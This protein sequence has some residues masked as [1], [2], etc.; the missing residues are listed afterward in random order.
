M[1]YDVGEDPP[2]ISTE[3]LSR[4]AECETATFGHIHFWGFCDYR[5]KAFKPSVRVAGRAITLAIPGFCSTLLHYALDRIKPGDI[6]LV[7]RL[8]DDRYACWGGGLTI[9]MKAAGGVA[10]VVDGPCTDAEELRASDFPIWCR[11]LSSITTRQSGSG[12]RLNRPVSIGGA[13]VMPGDLVLADESGVFVLNR[14]GV[15]AKI[16]Q[17][18]DFQAVAQPIEEQLRL[19]ASLPGLSG[20]RDRVEAALRT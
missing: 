19:G 13:V 7:D 12:G 16:Q 14:D 15:E 9:G 6:L 8:G 4:L 1:L 11:G 10:A 5:I 18:L 20:A 2:P 17:A 3:L